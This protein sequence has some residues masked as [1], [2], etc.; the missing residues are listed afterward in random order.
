MIFLLPFL[1]AGGN[2]DQSSGWS[3]SL[4]FVSLGSETPKLKKIYTTKINK[5][6]KTKSRNRGRKKTKLT[7]IN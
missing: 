1:D 2:T 6:D 5:K 3:L 4:G 7:F